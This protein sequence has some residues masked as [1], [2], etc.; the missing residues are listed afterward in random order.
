[1]QVGIYIDPAINYEDCARSWAEK[2]NQPFH[3]TGR[4]FELDLSLLESSFTGVF[5]ET[6]ESIQIDPPAFAQ[7]VAEYR[8]SLDE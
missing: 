6:L 7:R 4:D 1:M 3:T 2:F 8:S 5:P